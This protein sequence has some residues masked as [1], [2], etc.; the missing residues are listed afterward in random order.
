MS[1]IRP[2]ALRSLRKYRG[3][4]FAGL[5]LTT[6]L[7]IV[8]SSFGTTRLA[9]A[10]IAVMG[11]LIGHDAY[12][13]FKF[14]AGQGGAGVV[15][16]DERQVSYLAAGTGRSISLDTLERIELHRNMRGRTT[17]V[18]FG[19]EGMLSVPGDAE[20]TGKL[21]DALLALPGVNY[22]QAEAASQGR[23]PD[24]FLIWQRNRRK[25]H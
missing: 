11:A 18:F 1:F 10:V 15:E 13:R 25:L 17:W 22:A 5:V 7:M 3:F 6:G 14:P 23:G 12:R 21:F 9:G 20:G 2:E 16:V 8:F 19:P 4:I 24:L